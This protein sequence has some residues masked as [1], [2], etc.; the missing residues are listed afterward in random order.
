MGH[1]RLFRKDHRTSSE[2]LSVEVIILII[3]IVTHSNSLLV[4]DM[5]IGLGDR[6]AVI[7]TRDSKLMVEL[8][9]KNIAIF[10]AMIFVGIIL[11]FNSLLARWVAGYCVNHR[12][13]LYRLLS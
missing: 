4:I 2:A 5:M 13:E 1:L 7:A 10:L 6:P 11:V 3:F 12:A 9:N 8:V